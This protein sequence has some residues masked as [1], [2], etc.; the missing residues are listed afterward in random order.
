MPE[1]SIAVE[2]SVPST[3]LPVSTAE[4]SQASI[5][6]D[7]ENLEQTVSNLQQAEKTEPQA[8]P[9]INLVSETNSPTVDA[10]NATENIQEKT[11]VGDT[12]AETEEKPSPEE[13]SIISGTENQT[14]KD[15][16]NDPLYQEK[17][18]KATARAIS[19]GEPLDAKKLQEEALRE[20]QQEKTKESTEGKTEQSA[21]D[22]RLQEAEQRITALLENNKENLESAMVTVSAADL[23]ILLK[24]L[25]GAKE[26]DPKKKETKLM[27]ILKLL[28]MLVLSGVIETGKAA[29]PSTSQ[30]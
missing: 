20:Y 18:G 24:A 9:D 15:L 7:I 26:V 11:T 6:P 19:K 17:L 8:N 23:A 13:P 28:G 1:G 10:V 21:A 2:A 5:I 14:G 29:I 3:S 12:K 22:K 27:L 4:S 30:R 25:A 16:Q